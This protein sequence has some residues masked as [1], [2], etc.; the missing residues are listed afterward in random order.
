MS[1]FQPVLTIAIDVT[2][3][4]AARKWYSETLGLEE[5]FATEEAGWADFKSP[6]E[7]TSIG[8][9]RLEAGQAPSGRGGTTVTFSV[10]NIEE[11]RA[12]LES[13][14]VKFDGPT[15]E[16]EGMVKLATFV[17]PDGNGLM[18]AESTMPG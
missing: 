2:D 9:N 12:T 5:Q 14:G 6:V 3:W 7:N 4:N 13:R 8:L 10:A 18:L 17:D 15:V 16:I 11:A 1:L